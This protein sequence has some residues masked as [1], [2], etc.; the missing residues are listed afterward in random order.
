[1]TCL[2]SLLKTLYSCQLGAWFSFCVGAG[3]VFYCPYRRFLLSSEVTLGQGLLRMGGGGEGGVSI[4]LLLNCLSMLLETGLSIFTECSMPRFFFYVYLSVGSGSRTKSIQVFFCLLF[5]EHREVKW[6]GFTPPHSHRHP[7][8]SHLCGGVRWKI[9]QKQATLK[10]PCYK[11]ATIKL[12]LFI[13]TIPFPLIP[14]TLRGWGATL[15]W[16]RFLVSSILL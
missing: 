10:H 8:P 5:I 6:Y 9:K 1:M 12:L 14:V 2:I 3:Q 11:V 15:R 7:N 13:R 4:Y 16:P